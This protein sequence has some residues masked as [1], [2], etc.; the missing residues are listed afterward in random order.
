MKMDYILT[1]FDALRNAWS[2]ISIDTYSI[3]LTVL[4]VMLTSYCARTHTSYK[5]IIIINQCNTKNM[6]DT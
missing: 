6:A 4:Y 5:K 3:Y 2:K 1:D